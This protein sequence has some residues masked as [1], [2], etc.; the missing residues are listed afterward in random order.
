MTTPNPLD[1]PD[2]LIRTSFLDWWEGF[3]TIRGH[4]GTVIREPVAN[5]LQRAVADAIEWCEA[6]QVPVRILILKPRKEGATTILAGKAYHL[7]R[8]SEAHCLCIGD[9]SETTQTMWDM[10]DC[11][12]SGDEFQEWGN[13]LDSFTKVARAGAKA[14][15]SH[16]ATAWTDTAGDNR[17]GQ[18]KTPTI[19]LADEVAHWGKDG[20]SASGSDTMLALLNSVRDVAGTYVLVSSTANGVGNWYYRTHLG[21]VTLDERKQGPKGNG[22]IKVFCPWHQSDWCQSRVTDDDK[23]EIDRTMS[24]TEIEGCEKW[25][26]TYEQ[27]M[28]R[29]MT[30]ATKCDNDERKFDQEYPPDEKSAFLTSGRPVFDSKG[31]E[32]LSKLVAAAKPIHGNV[33]T[34]M[35]M[36]AGHAFRVD[37]AGGWATVW[38]EPIYGC[39]YLICLDTMRGEQSQGAK[40]P[41]CHSCFVIR[42]AY[43]DVDK[44]RHNRRVVARLRHPVRWYS[45]VVAEKIYTLSKWFGGCIIVGETNQGLDV[46]DDLRDLGANLYYRQKFDRIN[47]GQSL[48]VLGWETNTNTRPI[49]I[50]ALIAAINEGQIDVECSNFLKEAQTFVYDSTGKACAQRGCHDDDPISL[51]IGLANMQF[52]SKMRPPVMGTPRAWTPLQPERGQAGGFGGATE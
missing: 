22:W 29:R 38:E 11:Y 52:A 5:G 26:W 16:N 9:Q 33:E 13:N 34:N 3:S 48:T 4:E 41:D 21:A 10:L 49:L 50:S 40:D 8:S 27:I 30:I 6:E 32:R 36:E 35:M 7:L 24:A 37:P 51:G 47:P 15:W 44:V 19:I 23:A 39:T 31:L 14:S 46:L 18:S 17:A 25:G 43:M 42:E 1:D 20:A 45:K 28:F 12:Q 2:E